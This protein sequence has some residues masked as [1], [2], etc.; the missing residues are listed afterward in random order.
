MA[1]QIV[2]NESD[3]ISP[4]QKRINKGQRDI[5]G[6]L[7][8]VDWHV[9]KALYE[10][11]EGLAPQLQQLDLSEVR[12]ELKKAYYASKKV[13]DIDPPGCGDDFEQGP[14]VPGDTGTPVDVSNPSQPSQ[15]S[16]QGSATEKTDLKEAA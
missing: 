11:V 12:K 15:P 3:K 5:N 7:C 8:Y 6:A 10:L 2:I 1:M 14:D 16:T 9:I 4:K 13:A